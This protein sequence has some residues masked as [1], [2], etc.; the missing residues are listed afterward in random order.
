MQQPIVRYRETKYYV[1]H[2]ILCK[3]EFELESKES[4]QE[5][6]CRCL[7]AQKEESCVTK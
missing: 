6:C 7:W 4:E 1:R 2:C 3:R 5:T